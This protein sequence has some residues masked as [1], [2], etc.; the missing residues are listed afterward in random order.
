MTGLLKWSVMWDLL[1]LYAVAYGAVA[2]SAVAN[3]NGVNAYAVAV[4]GLS[5]S[6]LVTTRSE[7]NSNYSC[8][9]KS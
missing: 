2:A 7:R 8:E 9:N 1:S 6:G 5:L 4:N 3:C